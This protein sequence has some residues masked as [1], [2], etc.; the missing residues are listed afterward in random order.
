[1]PQLETL[2]LNDISRIAIDRDNGLVTN[3]WLK[4]AG[5]E[6]MVQTGE[7]IN[8]FLREAKADKLLL[9]ALNIGTLLPQTKDWLSNTYYKSLSEL[10]LKKLARVLPE[11]LF[12]KL[13][14]EAVVTRAEALGAI[15]FEVKNFSS[16]QAAMRW[17]LD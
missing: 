1:M 3:T 7:R 15:S 12:N 11:N 2:L 10:G 14:F 17:L 13:S 8:R 16:D 5:H 4:Q 6:E 9:S